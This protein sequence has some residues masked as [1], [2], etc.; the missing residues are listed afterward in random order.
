M[1][2]RQALAGAVSH[3]VD[4]GA[5][6]L[7]A[8]VGAGRTFVE[9]RQLELSGLHMGFGLSADYQTP[10]GPIFVGWGRSEDA[11]SRFYFG[12]GRSLRF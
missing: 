10:F 2:G 3:S 9:R 11:G 7:T 5:L 1:W 4:V 8:R 12:A 6:R